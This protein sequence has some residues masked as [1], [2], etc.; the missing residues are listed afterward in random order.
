VTALGTP[1]VAR[2]LMLLVTL[3][4]A[5]RFMHDLGFAPKRRAGVVV[6]MGSVLAGAVD[7]GLK[8]PP[9]RWLML[10]APFS[11]GVTI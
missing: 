9:V 8:N 1:Y 3:G 6:E 10:A 5:W 4:V 2:A 11:G 7:G